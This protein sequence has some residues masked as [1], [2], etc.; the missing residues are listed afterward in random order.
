MSNG[1][2][3][4]RKI[5]GRKNLNFDILEE[6]FRYVIEPVHKLD[7]FDNPGY[8]H[9]FDCILV[10][11]EWCSAGVIQLW[12]QPFNKNH[13]K[14]RFNI[15]DVY[16]SCMNN[17]QL[18][19]LKDFGLVFP[20]L[21]HRRRQHPAFDYPSLIRQ[22]EYKEMLFTVW[23]WCRQTQS[24][25][26]QT[27][28]PA[29]I[30]LVRALLELF[31]ASGAKLTSVKMVLPDRMDQINYD[32]IGKYTK[33][34]AEPQIRDLTNPTGN[35]FLSGNYANFDQVFVTLSET[36]TK[37]RNLDLSRVFLYT[38]ERDCKNK[39]VENFCSLIS[40]QTH[41]VSFTLST[42]GDHQS[43]FM[44]ALRSQASSLRRVTFVLLNFENSPP[45]DGLA[46]CTKLEKIEC[47]RCFNITERAVAPLLSAKFSHLR[48]VKVI[49]F[50]SNHGVCP[51]FR[52]WAENINEQAKS[53]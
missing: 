7:E 5:S 9:L 53:Q 42:C 41:L 49:V 17:E 1:E 16:L 26:L 40:S 24:T 14:H 13:S 6:I 51:E 44:S 30:A 31:A 10:N 38:S 32:I 36:F 35:L 28:T 25:A 18:Q 29:A 15:I 50:G 23:E 8:K 43:K 2:S 46:A 37:V 3:I 48:E 11:R 33:I 22:L 19:I 47:I 12:K 27:S 52:N 34:L 39:L 21:I 45:F 4:S 20:N